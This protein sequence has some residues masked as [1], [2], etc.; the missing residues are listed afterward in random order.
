VGS[1]GRICQGVVEIIKALASECK[2]LRDR[3]VH[4]YECLAEDPELR[5]LE[6]Q[7]QEAKQWAS[8]VQVQ[9]KLLTVVEKM[10]R[11]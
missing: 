1:K 3:S 9:I 2:K 7:L 10:K 4:T 6:A 11:S 5:I 8:T